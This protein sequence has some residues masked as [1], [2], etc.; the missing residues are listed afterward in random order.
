MRSWQTILRVMLFS[1]VLGAAVAAC[2]DA[3]E[4]GSAATP[5][6]TTAPPATP[7]ATASSRTGIT[8]LD[9]VLDAL[10]S[11]DRDALRELIAYTKF[12]C[13]AT[14]EPGGPP[15][16][17]ESEQ[18]GDL[19]DI[20]PLSVC[21]GT[22]LRPRAIDTALDYLTKSSLYA[23]YGNL[24]SGRFSE[25]VT[26]QEDYIAVITAEFFPGAGEPDPGWEVAID[27]GRIVGLF[28]FCVGTPQELIE[29]RHYTDA[30][31]PPQTP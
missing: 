1:L 12:A 14:T 27:D 23:V 21:E 3:N 30:V 11:R 7:T 26:Y 10:N 2:G 18:P 6:A 8:A 17:E 13:G 28:L 4:G 25:V 24:P 15:L 20:F 29:Q 5:T 31:L 9:P 22:P 19:A 16:C